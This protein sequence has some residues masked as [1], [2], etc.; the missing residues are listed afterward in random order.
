LN[1]IFF[2]FIKKKSDVKN[3]DGEDKECLGAEPLSKVNNKYDA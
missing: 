1:D 3:I 2:Q